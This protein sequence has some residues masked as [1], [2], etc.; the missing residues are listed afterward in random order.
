M[1]GCCCRLHPHVPDITFPSFR[2]ASVV[3]EDRQSS[4]NIKLAEFGRYGK[5]AF[6]LVAMG[7][8]AIRYTDLLSQ[9]ETLSNH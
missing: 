9:G 1:Y 4:F 6:G 7:V 5:V 3:T 8:Q 2:P